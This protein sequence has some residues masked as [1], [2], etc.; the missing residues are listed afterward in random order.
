MPA[1]RGSGQARSGRSSRFRAPADTSSGPTEQTLR[2]RKPD[3]LDLMRRAG[4]LDDAAFEAAVALR[5]GFEVLTAGAAIARWD[6]GNLPNQRST[7]EWE[8]EYR[9]RYEERFN[10][11]ADLMDEEGL[12]VGLVLDIVVEGMSCRETDSK[13]RKRKGTA[14]EIL[15][16]GLDLYCVA[17]RSHSRGLR[18]GRHT[19]HNVAM[20]V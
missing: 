20:P 14:R 6:Y 19:P 3:W 9:R 15:R 13:W 8:P 16:Q 11:W 18:R 17:A 2:R 5:R 12:P 4:T 1:K 7:G 10:I